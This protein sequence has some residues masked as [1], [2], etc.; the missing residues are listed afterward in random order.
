[1]ALLIVQFLT[2]G[3]V[4][5]I[6]PSLRRPRRTRLTGSPMDRSEASTPGGIGSYSGVI[7]FS[8]LPFGNLSGFRGAILSCGAQNNFFKISV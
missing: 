3:A 4:T 7:F 1:M 8:G 6:M 5:P 2:N